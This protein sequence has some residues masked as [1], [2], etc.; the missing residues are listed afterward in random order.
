[1]TKHKVFISYHHKND[2]YYKEKF[3]EYFEKY[4]INKSVFEGE[5]DEELSDEYVKRLIREDKISDCSVV[6][7][8]IGAE[9][10]KRKHIDWE[11]Y[12]GLTKKAGGFSGLIGIILP[13]Y[14]NAEE[15]STLEKNHYYSSTIPPR[16]DDNIKSGYAIICN[17][18]SIKHIESNGEYAI[19]NW[20]ED[21]YKR[22][23]CNFDKIDNSRLQF[24]KNR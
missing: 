23:C 4:F 1:M 2:E 3:E 9:T 13:S 21:A 16:L 24:Q 14:Y 18:D 22:Q 11:I 12:A 17:W 15:N 5:Y 10:Y 20:I 19:V 7:V 6:V 8:L